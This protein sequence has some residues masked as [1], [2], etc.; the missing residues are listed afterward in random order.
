[1]KSTLTLDR[2]KMIIQGWYSEYCRD[3]GKS[4][5][6]LDIREENDSAKGAYKVTNPENGAST[7]IPLSTISDYE[8]SGAVGIPEDFKA[9][10]WDTLQDL[11]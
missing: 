2:A 11:G 4:V 5:A 7:S 9:F 6:S 3:H 8:A 10:V 1:M